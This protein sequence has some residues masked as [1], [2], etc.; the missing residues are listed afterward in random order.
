MRHLNPQ[1]GGEEGPLFFLSESSF[2]TA[3]IFSSSSLLV[4]LCAVFVL[5]G[6]L[7]LLHLIRSLHT[8]YSFHIKSY[9]VLCSCVF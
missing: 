8:L 4:L 5:A 1:W 6:D 9:T 7:P 3:F 2:Q